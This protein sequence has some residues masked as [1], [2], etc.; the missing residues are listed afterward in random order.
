MMGTCRQCLK[1]G[2]VISGVIGYCADCIRKDFETV[3]PDIQRVHTM[4]R[5]AVKLPEEPP[6]AE[7]GILC[8]LCFQACRIPEGG[9][10]YCGQRNVRR[11][12]LVGGRPHEGNLSA[13]HDPLPTNCVADFVC[14]G[15]TGCGYP[16]FAHTRGPEQGFKNLAVFYQSCSFNC[17][18]C[19]N[20]HFRAQSSQTGRF[21]A[22][23]LACLADRKTACICFFGG[24]PSPQIL[25]AIKASRQ[26]RKARNQSILRVCWETNGAMRRP[27]L[28]A[29]AD[30]ALTSGGCIKVDL[31]AWTLPIHRAL[32]GVRH[33][34]TLRNFKRLAQRVPER[35]SPP[36]LVASTL[37]VPGY[38]DEEEV[39]G[40]AAFIA[41]LNPEI[42][43]RLLAFYPQFYLTDLPTT[44]RA[45]ALRCQ[46]AARDA[47]LK[48]VHIGNTH[49]LGP[50]DD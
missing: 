41:A 21:P 14:P 19:Q 2:P 10:G 1:S 15:G 44:S 32:C 23:D 4:S 9:S 8:P 43:Y 45:Q 48:R 24:D 12:Q 40:I 49:L 50:T 18:F 29:M 20:H 47:G 13:Y 7:E 33:D 17:L 30:M 31:K 22:R 35:P 28:Q 5:R 27:Y 26:A 3:W 16:Q 11:G 36:F 25:H 42:P 39:A 34:Q 38:V 6:R 46:A 37:M